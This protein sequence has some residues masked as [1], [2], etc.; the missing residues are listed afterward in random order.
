MVG[1]G[2]G[3]VVQYLTGR[4]RWKV[5]V[6]AQLVFATSYLLMIGIGHL[7]I[8]AGTVLILVG[9]IVYTLGELTGGP[10]TAAISAEAAPE[11][12][13]GRY[14]SL[15]Q[16]SWGIAATVTPV[17]FMWLLEQGT[18]PMWLAMLG[19][20]AIGSALGLQLGRVMPRA[21]DVITNRAEE[22]VVDGTATA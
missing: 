5:I 3:L 15:I 13:L 20:T 21:A 6:G 10:V 9:A 17:A 8:V 4:V 12:L 14:L 2:Q 11:H 18:S 16:M 19:L 7:G 22:P 1:F